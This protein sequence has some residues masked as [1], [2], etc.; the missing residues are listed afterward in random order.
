MRKLLDRLNLKKLNL[1]QVNVYLICCFFFVTLSYFI[2]KAFFGTGE[3][4]DNIFVTSIPIFCELS[5]LLIVLGNYESF[6]EKKKDYIIFILS[7]IIIFLLW[8]NSSYN[9]KNLLYFIFF[10]FLTL[11]FV[12]FLNKHSNKNEILILLTFLIILNSLFAEIDYLNKNNLFLFFFIYLSYFIIFTLSFRAKK[13]I[14]A[15]LSLVVFLILLKVF[16]LSSEK[17]SFHYSFIIGSGYSSFFDNK[18]L[19]E[20]VSQYGYVNIL[21]IELVSN[22]TN[23]RIDSSLILVIIFFLI[24]FFI[25]LFNQIKKITNYP[26]LIIVTFISIILF[27]NIGVQN[28]AGSILIPSS[29]V[30][31]FLPA[32]IVMLFLS[33]II[34]AKHENNKKKNIYLFYFFLTI[35][36]LWSF[37]SFFFIFFSLFFLLLFIIIISIIDKNVI[38]KR[39]YFN[40]KFIFYQSFV[41]FF[42]F[43]FFIFFI[44]KNNQIIFFYEYVFNGKSIKNIDIS[45]SGYTLVFVLFLIIKYLF[46]R[47]SFELKNLKYFFNNVIWFTLFVSFSAY[48]VT[49]SI[50][51]NLFALF[52]FYI[53]FLASM[54]SEL[55]IVNKIRKLF[56]DIF[57]FISI[58][59]FLLS[60]YKNKE[61]FY[62]NF[63][64]PIFF[65]LPKYKYDYYKPSLKLQSILERFKDTPLTLI[66]GNTI[67]NYNDSLNKG[68]Y[69]LPILPL[70][71]FN[72]LS[73]NR[74]VE[75]MNIFFEKNKQHLILC[76]VECSF[77]NE[78]SAKKSW[79]DI[80]IP[81]DFKFTEVMFQ[82]NGHEI[83][84]LIEK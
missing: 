31:R 36:S 9:Y 32:I 45:N 11:M 7:F 49:R 63:L 83:L 33:R 81:L 28:L 38:F 52:P 2:I 53:Y 22:F 39:I 66:T 74:K 37:E 15:V 60:C 25:L 69:G 3:F 68:G 4:S 62:K 24:I 56:F 16:I 17:D 71:Q 12:I 50:Y 82:P 10:N 44:V 48:Y 67:H 76:L 64:S 46:L 73:N 34:F 20:V 65:T 1:E 57:I 79:S 47:S 77:Y 35:G 40:Q 75:L 26:I 21:F 19:N 27:A 23:N 80:F 29:S 59:A 18:L 43:L 30:F 55:D 61:I 72:I 8:D 6:L 13:P 42:I 84:Y 41:L 54:R 14:N 51:T 70:E 58:T 78:K 5:L